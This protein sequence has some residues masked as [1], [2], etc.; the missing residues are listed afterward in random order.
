MLFK[1][2]ESFINFQAQLLDLTWNSEKLFPQEIDDLYKYL[3][4]K[5]QGSSS[6]LGKILNDLVLIEDLYIYINKLIL[7]DNKLGLHGKYQIIKL[8]ENIGKFLKDTNN[9]SEQ[10]VDIINGINRYKEIIFIK[11]NK[12]QLLE[13]NKNNQREVTKLILDTNNKRLIEIF[14][15]NIPE[16]FLDSEEEGEFGQTVEGVGENNSLFTV[17]DGQKDLIGDTVNIDS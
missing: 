4:Y 1:Y 11:E 10:E 5:G 15:Q 12:H 2:H 17:K 9:A 3:L 14:K 6:V 7:L 8:F 16:L 13:S